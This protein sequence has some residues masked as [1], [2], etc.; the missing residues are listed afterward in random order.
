[1][2][3][4]P[5]RK[6]DEAL[7]LLREIRDLLKDMLKGQRRHEAAPALLGALEEHFGPAR[8]TVKGVLEVAGEDPHG[9]LAVA[10]A[11]NVDMNLS[12]R[13]RATALGALLVRLR[14]L[15][16]VAERP[17]IYRLRREDE[18]IITNRNNA[19]SAENLPTKVGEVRSGGA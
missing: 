6:P 18:R 11:Q 17:G 8:F 16:V 9:V 13:S 3:A 15:E 4:I 10:V 7:E 1:V 14:E 19:L 12:P 2:S 5:F